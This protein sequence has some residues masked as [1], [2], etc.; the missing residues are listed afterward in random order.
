M[1][2]DNDYTQSDTNGINCN[3]ITNDSH[4]NDDQFRITNTK[5]WLEQSI[6]LIH[7]PAPSLITTASSQVF[8][9]REL[10]QMRHLAAGDLSFSD[11]FQWLLES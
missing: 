8:Q 6:P 11:L 4:R 3:R 9:H 2:I 1:L 7:G 5:P 10:D